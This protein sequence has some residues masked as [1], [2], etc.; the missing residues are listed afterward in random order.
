MVVKGSHKQTKQN[1]SRLGTQLGVTFCNGPF[2]GS[3]RGIYVHQPRSKLYSHL[4]G[5]SWVSFFQGSVLFVELGARNQKEHRQRTFVAVKNRWKEGIPVSLIALD[6]R[7][8]WG[9]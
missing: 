2:G 8:F 6:A 4:G 5:S 1:V 7:V 3:R 9:R